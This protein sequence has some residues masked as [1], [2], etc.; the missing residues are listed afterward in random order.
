VSAL[1]SASTGTQT[2]GYD[3]GP[4]GEEICAE[5][6]A[7]NSC[8]VR[9][10][11]KYQDSETD[12][13]YYGERYYSAVTGRWL[14]RD[15]IDEED[16]LNIYAFVQNDPSSG[17]DSDGRLLFKPQAMMQRYFAGRLNSF[18]AGSR[19]PLLGGAAGTLASLYQA[20]ADMMDPSW[21]DYLDRTV[22][23]YGNAGRIYDRERGPCGKGKLWAAYS[24]A[25]FF[26]GDYFGLNGL[27]EGIYGADLVTEESLNGADRWSRGLSG[28]ANSIL[29]AV[30]AVSRFSAANRPVGSTTAQLG[31]AKIDDGIPK[32]GIARFDQPAV[33]AKHFNRFLDL[34][35]KQGYRVKSYSGL[36]ERAVFR[37]NRDFV[38]NPKTMTVIDMLHEIKHIQQLRRLG[39]KVHGNPLS[40]VEAYNFERFLLKN[41]PGVNPDYLK[42][43]EGAPK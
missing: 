6:T 35:R 28:F 9:F 12:L 39:F 38:Y 2:A 43:L 10:S 40:E 41:Q 27:P 20:T 31:L 15:P 21:S 5:G 24:A 23:R 42:F 22:R 29:F 33:K 7:A 19:S 32:T 34:V 16:G 30:P 4:F 25:A 18:A 26:L 17:V 1:V 37:P 8:P 36:S 14:S 13:L 11:T 3:F